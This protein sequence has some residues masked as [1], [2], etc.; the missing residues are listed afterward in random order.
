MLQNS[1]KYSCDVYLNVYFTQTWKC[2]HLLTYMFQKKKFFFLLN[3]NIFSRMLITKQ[4]L[5]AT[6]VHSIKK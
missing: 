3:T 4:L 6:D 5:V 2:C 1:N